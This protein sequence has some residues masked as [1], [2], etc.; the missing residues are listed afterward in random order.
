M[1]RASSDTIARVTGGEIFFGSADAYATGLTV[2]S[3]ETTAGCAFVALPGEHSDGH[4][5]AI[6]ALRRG[7]RVL[8]VTRPEEQLTTLLGETLTRGATLV[9]VEDGLRAVIDLATWHRGR[10]LCPVVGVTGSTGKTTT[11]DFM[12]AALSSRLR[13]ES[14]QG[15]RNNELGVPLTVLAAGTNTEVL[16]VEMG[17]RGM[18]QIS[19]LCRVARPTLGLITNVGTSHIEMLGSQ[20]AIARAKGELVEAIPPDGAVFLNGDDVHTEGLASRASAPITRYGLTSSC[21]V[22]AT[23]IVLDD[24]SRATFTLVAPQGSVRVSLPVPGR[25]NVYNALAAASVALRLA[26][27]MDAISEGLGAAVITAMRMETIN[28]ASGVTVINDAY[29][30]NPTSMR[31]AIDTLSAM[32]T[33]G[34]RV[35]VLGDMGELGNLSEIAHL[36]LGEFVAEKQIDVLVAVG[37]KARRIAEGAR[38]RGMA[39]EMI[40]PCA[41]PEEAVGVLDDLVDSGDIV[42]VKASRMMGLETVVEGLVDPRVG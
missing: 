1:L 18:G 16:L 31:A 26:L 32:A 3:R 40:R 37:R 11:K 13:V 34:K 28:A 7:A 19:E 23:D 10:L 35:A 14:T 15:N 17:M 42:L 22:R 9:R 30:A 2:D 25:H 6:D 33:V 29:N 5:H 4:D 27:P 39:V 12:R 41:T 38:A 36:E 24:E 20:E 8:I 21:D